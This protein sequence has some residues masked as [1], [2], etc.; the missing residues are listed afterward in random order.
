[1]GRLKTPGSKGWDD[2]EPPEYGW[3]DTKIS[4]S[5]GWDDLKVHDEKCCYDLGSPGNKGGDEQ[6]D[7]KIKVGT[8]KNSWG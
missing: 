6:K 5:E 1:M 7:L 4:N 3:G 2:K 8:I